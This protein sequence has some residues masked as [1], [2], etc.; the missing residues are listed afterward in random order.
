M[1][2]I[3]WDVTIQKLVA[4][5]LIALLDTFIMALPLLFSNKVETYLKWMPWLN[6]LASGLTIGLSILPLGKNE[7]NGKILVY[8]FLISFFVHFWMKHSTKLKN[9]SIIAVNAK[10]R[11]ERENS[12]IFNENE[13]LP[14]TEI[15]NR[16]ISSKTS[17]RTLNGDIETT[18]KSGK[19][20]QNEKIEKM[21]EEFEN[22]LRESYR[23]DE[24]RQM[25]SN[26]IPST[27]L[28]RSIDIINS[29]NS[30]N[31][32][33][34]LSSSTPN[35]KHGLIFWIVAMIAESFFS[36]FVLGCQT[37]MQIVWILFATIMCG[38]WAECIIL[39]QKI[40]EHFQARSVFFQLVIVFS[41][42]L[43]SVFGFLI[44]M[45]GIMLNKNTQTVLSVVLFSC[46]CGLFLYIAIVDMMMREMYGEKELTKE[47]F[48]LKSILIL[49]GLT[50]AIVMDT[51]FISV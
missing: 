9:N 15:N 39:G 51:Y 31:S 3:E 22:V 38:D 34:Q 45:L 17:S 29:N 41:M 37:S 49:T 4:V 33:L 47:R 35:T 42:Q 13:T 19:E 36:C 11:Q 5:T 10:K 30:R 28:D 18:D 26:G 16:E 44:G 6:S 43:A 7:S 14:T 48:I 40:H 50:L 23:E 21:D 27:I 25:V 2:E 24:R 8:T 20:T 46:I 32:S 12:I 1:I